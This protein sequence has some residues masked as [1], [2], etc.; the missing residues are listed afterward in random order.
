[1]VLVA[2][3]AAG[4]WLYG[5]RLPSVLSRAASGAADKV[6]DAAVRTSERLDS[7][8]GSRIA[9]EQEARRRSAREARDRELG[10]VT[11]NADRPVPPKVNPLAPLK[12]RNG[13]AYVSL[14]AA[15]VAGLLAPLLQQLPP[16]SATAQLALDGDQLLVRTAVSLS[17]FTGQ[18]AIGSVLGKALVG[19]DTLFLAGSLEPVRPGLAEFRVRELRLKG[20]DV[21][22]RLIPG[23]VRSL[24]GAGTETGAGTAAGTAPNP[25]VT[26][27]GVSPG[28]LPVP[29]PATVSDVRVVNGKLTLYRASTSSKKP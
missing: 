22:T 18:T 8:E 9:A 15:Q 4:Y 23:I 26:T 7:E 27:E 29:L 2:G 25:A 13:P 5:D 3:G 14:D 20:I 21:P 12:R 19:E 17:D 11:V 16:S 6:T 24:R 1:M 10:W 28:A